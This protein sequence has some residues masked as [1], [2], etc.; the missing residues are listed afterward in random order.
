MS[1]INAATPRS[2]R[3]KRE[4]HRVKSLLTNIAV[5]VVATTSLP[6]LS[7]PPV[8][9]KQTRS[10]PSLDETL[11]FIQERLSSIGTIGFT[12]S[13]L[14]STDQSMT[15]HR[16]IYELSTVEVST[17]H[18]GMKYHYHRVIDDGKPAD[19]DMTIP[20]GI[21][22]RIQVEPVE[23]FLTK[24]NSSAG[25][26]EW[27]VT[28]TQPQTMVLRFMTREKAPFWVGW[29]AFYLQDRVLTDR[30]ARALTRAVEL[31][32]GGNKDPF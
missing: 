20:F 3:I 16:S 15:S 13:V 1:G 7:A 12:A 31:C 4:Y 21:V 32:G 9:P 5:L 25:H 26:P 14:T 17:T 8:S 11:R 10:Q 2:E 24:D 18:C 27:I 19:V 6:V 23:Q 30:V 29:A 22:E 28:N